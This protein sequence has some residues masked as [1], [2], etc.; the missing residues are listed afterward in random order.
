MCLS[1]EMQLV[2]EHMDKS[3]TF[4]SALKYVYNEKEMRH[5]PLLIKLFKIKNNLN[6]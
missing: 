4:F 3:S 1:K 6:I 5:G 2:N